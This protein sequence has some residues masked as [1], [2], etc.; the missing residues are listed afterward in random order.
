MTR[1]AEN[2][3]LYFGKLPS[4]GDFV[5]SAH[6]PALIQLLDRWL[7]GGVELL[8][9]DPLWKTLYDRAEPVRFAF[10]GSRHSRGLVG[11]L[12]AS[13]DAS[14]RRFPFITATTFESAEPLPFLARSPLAL[15]RIWSLL[16]RNARQAHAAADATPVL[17]EWHDAYLPLVGEPA[18]YDASFTDF[19]EMQTVGSLQAM[20]AGA[21]HVVNVRQL[22]LG[23]GLLL[24]PVLASGENRLERGLLLPLPTEPLYAPVVAAYWLDLVAG[25]LGRAAFE[26]ALFQPQASAGQPHFLAIGFEGNSPKSLH[27]LLDPEQMSSVYIDCRLAEWV[28]DL[29][30]QDYAVHKLSSYLQQDGLSLGQAALTFK[31]VFL[32]S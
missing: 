1:A 2:P 15:A 21:G 26:L 14:G 6:A 10:L 18:A 7:S 17:A 30:S 19:C 31:E 3:Q 23:L 20:L 8:A 22:V 13:Q 29:L 4:R 12:I 16:D 28:E 11:H 25:F 27:A 9:A 5:R 24:Q 32:G